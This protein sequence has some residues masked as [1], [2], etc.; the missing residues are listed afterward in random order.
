MFLRFRASQVRVGAS[1]RSVGCP[2]L[3]TMLLCIC[4]K[5]VRW[6]T[7]VRPRCSGQKRQLRCSSTSPNSVNFIPGASRVFKTFL[8]AAVYGL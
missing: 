5:V 3:G 2:F 6:E 1:L 7:G 4:D 8:K